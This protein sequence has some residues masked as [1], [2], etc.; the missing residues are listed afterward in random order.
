MATLVAVEQ[1][2]ILVVLWLVMYFSRHQMTM[3]SL[4]LDISTSIYR[5][6]RIIDTMTGSIGIKGNREIVLP[7]NTCSRH[8]DN[9]ARYILQD[10]L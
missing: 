1:Q 5:M 3:F 9:S 7:S 2:R 6:N 10:Q 4:H 8:L